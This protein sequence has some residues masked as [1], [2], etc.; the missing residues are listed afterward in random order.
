[1]ASYEESYQVLSINI[2]TLAVAKSA[3]VSGNLYQESENYSTLGQTGLTAFLYG[4][5][6]KNRFYIIKWLKK[7]KK[8]NIYQL[9]TWLPL[10]NVSFLKVETLFY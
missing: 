6:T 7:I 2:C 9:I 4:P 5:H 8:I 1:M 3:L 10:V